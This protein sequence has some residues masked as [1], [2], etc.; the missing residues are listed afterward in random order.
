MVMPTKRSYIIQQQIAFI[1]HCC[2]RDHY[3]P[4]LLRWKSDQYATLT[5][6]PVAAD[7]HFVAADL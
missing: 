6:G 3:E 5:Y 7:V 4:R 1:L 2:Y